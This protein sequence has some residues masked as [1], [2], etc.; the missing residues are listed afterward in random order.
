M[1]GDKYK[2]LLVSNG[3]NLNEHEYI[4]NTAEISNDELPDM[5]ISK[6]F[7]QQRLETELG[8]ELSNYIMTLIGNKN[9]KTIDFNELMKIKNDK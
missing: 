5:K 4:D 3:K 9:K 6:E 8:K 1:K 7:L 2:E